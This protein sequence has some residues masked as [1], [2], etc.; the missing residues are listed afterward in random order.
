[1][2]SRRSRLGASAGSGMAPSIGATSCG[3]VPH[4]TM[5]AI[6]ELSRLIS[7]SKL[8][9]RITRKLAPANE[10]PVPVFALG[11]VG[12]PSQIGEGGLIRCDHA[13][14]RAGLDR[15]VAN[16]EAT[17]HRQIFDR[18]ARIFDHMPRCASRADAADNRKND[19][20][21]AYAS[22]EPPIDRD[23][24]R[25]GHTLPKR[26]SRQDVVGFGHS[27]AKGERADRAMCRRMTV[28]ADDDHSRLADALLGTDD[29]HDP[30]PLVFQAKHLDAEIRSVSGQR[31]DHVPPF[32]VRDL[33]RLARIGG[34]VVIGGRESLRWRMRLE[35]ARHQEF[36]SR[37]V[38]VVNE[39]AIDVEQ[40]LA[41][42]PLKDA[43]SR[44]D[45]LEHGSSRCGRHRKP[46]F[47][48]PSPCDS[49]RRRSSAAKS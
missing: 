47:S 12:P 21:G 9:S 19:V 29:V 37:S 38:A 23:A 4:V 2:L 44:P 17:F 6:S 43:V 35:A 5:G 28:G 8:A 7:L 39:V 41:V 25:P 48:T 42:R 36:E 14:T 11:R 18:R 33:R 16:S 34:H 49:Y 15:H 24:H 27:K 3:L 45:L 10:R 32:G 20:F 26:L 46:P 40:S 1:M 30:V 31:F 22:R 13:C